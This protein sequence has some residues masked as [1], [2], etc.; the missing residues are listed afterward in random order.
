MTVRIL[1]FVGV[2]FLV[3]STRLSAA[4]TG[5][6][7]LAESN[8]RLLRGPAVLVASEGVRIQPGDLLETGNGGISVVEFADGLLIGLGPNS[9][10][11]LQEGNSRSKK[12]EP[13]QAIILL[14]GWMKLESGKQAPADDYRILTAALGV[15]TRDAKL[16]VHAAEQRASLFVESGSGRILEPDEAGRTVKG[17]ALG[18]G[19]FASRVAAQRTSVQA[20]PDAG[21]LANMPRGFRDALPARPERL[22]ASPKAP[23][24]DHDAG[25]D[26]VKDLLQLPQAW[27]SE[28]VRRF[29]VRLRD[30]G[31]R[32]AVAA[33]MARHPEWHPILYPPR[34]PEARREPSREPSREPLRY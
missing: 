18:A 14:S 20:K 7:T 25:Y 2:F 31:F 10:L 26:E 8:L 17:A 5:V 15:G 29:S 1:H 23:K 28:M 6:I 3:L 22:K 16:L 19:Q 13:G 21:F 24:P 9:R 32:K 34:P 27:R 30:A 4:E 33:N 12:A 11:Y